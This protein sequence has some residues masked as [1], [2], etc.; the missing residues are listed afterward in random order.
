MTEKTDKVTPSARTSSLSLTEVANEEIALLAALLANRRAYRHHLWLRCA[1]KALVRCRKGL[2]SADSRVQQNVKNT[3]E[4]AAAECVSE[5][6]QVRIDTIGITT[7]L[8]A[9]LSRL[10]LL[11]SSGD[12]ASTQRLSVSRIHK[13]HRLRGA[14]AGLRLRNALRGDSASDDEE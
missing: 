14:I 2:R 13:R 4:R 7:A 10:H 5:I 3:L 6:R 1:L 9:V 8:L 12:K 11:F